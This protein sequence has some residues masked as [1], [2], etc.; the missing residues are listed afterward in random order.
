MNFRGSELEPE[1][2]EVKLAL[3]LDVVLPLVGSKRKDPVPP[4]PPDS[5][6][7]EEEDC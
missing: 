5:H 1:T 2:L 6:T 4:P 7:D 3:V